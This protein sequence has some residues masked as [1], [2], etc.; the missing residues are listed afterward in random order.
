M[1]ISII[2][3]IAA[4]LAGLFIFAPK[5]ELQTSI[6]IDAP[7]TLVWDILSD[8]D[9]HADWNPFLVSMSGQLQE[10]ERLTNVMR[11]F[12]GKEMTFRPVVLSVQPERELRWLGRLFVP[13]LF[14]GEHTF[15]LAPQNGGTHFIQKEAFRGIG[16]WFIN[17]EQVRQ[18]FEALNRAL[19]QR[20]EAARAT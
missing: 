4:I 13:R 18:D 2:A 3:L 19:R 14:D 7:P 20:A 12:N 11:P 15:L 9:G 17:I 16:L 5:A 6:Q 1:L 8:V 10:G